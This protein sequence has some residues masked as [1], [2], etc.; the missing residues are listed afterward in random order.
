MK[1]VGGEVL[2][3]YI[4]PSDTSLLNYLQKEMKKKQKGKKNNYGE[5]LVSA[6]YEDGVCLNKKFGKKFYNWNQLLK[7]YEFLDGSICG[8]V[9]RCR[10]S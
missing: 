1:R 5:F 3:N 9:P 10:E 4:P 6:I 7:N 8:I 2:K